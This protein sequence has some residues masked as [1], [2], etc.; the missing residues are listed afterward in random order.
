[1]K[2]ALYLVAVLGLVLTTACGNPKLKNGEEV[3]AKI[4]GKKYTADNLYKELKGKYGYSTIMGW[5]DQE[6]AEKE[7]ETTDEITKEVEET[8]NYYR[9]YAESYGM[10]LAQFAA[11]YLGLSVSSDDEL[12][13][14]IENDKKL[15]IAIENQVASK[16]KDSEIEDYYN[17]N[18][19]TVYTYRDILISTD[20]DKDKAIKEIKKELKDKKGDK[21]VEAFEKMAKSEYSASTSTDAIENATK[22]VVDE[23][24]WKALKDLDNYE[25]SDGIEASDG[26]HIILRISKN[27]GKALKDIKEE[28]KK[29]MA[30][31]KLKKE[32]FLSYDIL[33]ELRN[34]YKLAFFDT[35]LKDGYDKF[36]EELDKAKK[37]ASNS[38]SN[39]NSNSKEEK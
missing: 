6:I 9:Q 38:N 36:L 15:N 25:Y 29:T 1:M 11:N 3:I 17:E 5:I 30:Q 27:D 28:V 16:F 14:F 33:T 12:K 34:K 19:K 7:V 32:Q 26:T 4:E 37:Q 13:K 35:E 10:S 22:N 2:K 39:S 24:I 23:K 20:K 21:L 8:L 31:E 18:Y